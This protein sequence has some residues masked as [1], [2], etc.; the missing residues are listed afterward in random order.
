MR[1]LFISI[2]LLLTTPAL[3]AT[4]HCVKPDASAVIEVDFN[5]VEGA[6]FGTVDGARVTTSGFVLSSNAGENGNPEPDTLDGSDMVYDRIQVGLNSERFGW[7]CASISC[8][9]PTTIA[10]SVARSKRSSR[11]RLCSRHRDDDRDLH[12]LVEV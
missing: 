7:H 8:A 2:L 5:L 4:V 3:S 12:R 11:C 10:I 1:G 6:D 9:R